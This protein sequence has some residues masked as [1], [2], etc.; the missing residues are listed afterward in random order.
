MAAAITLMLRCD[1]V[2]ALPT[3]QQSKGAVREIRAA[4]RA[5]RPVFYGHEDL[6]SWLN[7]RPVGTFHGQRA[8]LPELLAGLP[9][10]LIL[11]CGSRQLEIR[12]WR[13][14]ADDGLLYEAHTIGRMIRI[15]SRIAGVEF[16]QVD[17]AAPV[18]EMEAETEPKRVPLNKVMSEVQKIAEQP[19]PYQDEAKL[20]LRHYEP[21]GR[22]SW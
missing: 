1:A 17:E 11:R 22:G 21:P 13:N 20:L 8:P 14:E 16:V 15:F 10:T 3:W 19:G 18:V 4:D 9:Q 2:L 12:Q 5:T 7:H 6:V